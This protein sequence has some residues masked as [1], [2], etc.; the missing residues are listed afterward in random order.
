MFPSRLCDVYKPPSLHNLDIDDD[1][2]C[3]YLREHRTRL[4]S[5]DDDAMA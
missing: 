2:I 4:M 3:N 5:D 1:N